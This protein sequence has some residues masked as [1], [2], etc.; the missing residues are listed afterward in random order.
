MVD[1]KPKVSVATSDEVASQG[2]EVI[3]LTTEEEKALDFFVAAPL[4]SAKNLMGKLYSSD[5][6]YEQTTY[7][8]VGE[9]DAKKLFLYGVC[10][11]VLKTCISLINS[12]E[13]LQERPVNQTKDLIEKTV[14]GS[15]TDEQDYR[16]RKM[17]ELLAL[18]IVF[19]RTE[20]KEKEY[21][22]YRSA[23][24]LDISLSRQGDFREVYGGETVSNVQHSIDD[25]TDRIRT[26]LETLS[27]REPFFL[28]AGKVRE[29]KVSV[30][31]S[32]RKIFF[33]ALL[34]ATDEERFALGITY[35]TT[36]TRLSLSVHPWMGSHDYGENNKYE[37]VRANFGFI[38]ILCM[39]VMHLAHSLAGEKDPEGWERLLA[40]NQGKSEATK[41]MASMKKSYDLGDIVLTKWEDLGE[42]IE[43]REGR[44]GYKAYK[45]KHLTRAPIP[46]HVEDWYKAEDILI[47]LVGKYSVRDFYIRTTEKVEEKELRHEMQKVLKQ[48]DD[49]LLEAAKSMYIDL[50]KHKVLIPMLL[51]SGSLKR[52]KGEE[53]GSSTFSDKN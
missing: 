6:F 7:A 40:A 52:K 15:I 50:H 13:F 23:E 26:D 14:Y 48:S 43:E 12:K 44:F 32:K 1:E 11:E 19:D 16:L 27:G 51:E 30:F 47:K 2:K 42:V 10:K 4:R 9:K 20:C 18:L 21:R 39:H 31:R 45:I 41:H 53:K 24:N 8:W 35:H 34:H 5:T 33:E 29:G 37:T 22:I 25:F 28:D 46:E 49:W 38:S 17:I 36:Y 3:R